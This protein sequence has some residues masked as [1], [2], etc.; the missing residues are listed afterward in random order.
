M[1]EPPADQGHEVLA[2]DASNIPN[3]GERAA[4]RI[5][6]DASDDKLVADQ[7]VPGEGLHDA[8]KPAGQESEK[9]QNGDEQK[10]RHDNRKVG[11]AL[12]KKE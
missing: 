9:P 10:P 3:D 6:I 7:S 2:Q 5:K 11:L 12:V 4:K 1:A 8:P